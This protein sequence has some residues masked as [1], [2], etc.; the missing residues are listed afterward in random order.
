MRR[1]DA[2]R[3]LAWSAGRYPNTRRSLTL[4]LALLLSLVP[5]CVFGT[6]SIDERVRLRGTGPYRGQVLDAVTKQPIPG[7]V[8]VAVW[9][10]SSPTVGGDVQH[11]HDALETVTDAQGHFLI[12]A[13]TIERS[14]PRRT[15]FP[16]FTF[17]KSGYRYFKGWFAS[18]EA[19]ADRRN[20]PLLGVVELTPL[21]DRKE[22]LESWRDVSALRSFE[23]DKRL[24][25]F[26][27]ALAEERRA[28]GLGN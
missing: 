22:R 5:G 16:D 28:L 26:L 10:Y 1:K 19:M 15:S 12:D 8:V 11:V 23:A 4:T 14:A 7:V 6:P 3:S 2:R 20:R 27:N 25:V 13:P 9:Y 21:T 17:F 24:P 18:P